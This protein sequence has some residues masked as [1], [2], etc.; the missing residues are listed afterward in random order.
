MWGP[1]PRHGVGEYNG[2]IPDLLRLGEQSLEISLTPRHW[3]FPRSLPTMAPVVVLLNTFRIGGTVT[4]G[5][6][7]AEKAEYGRQF[8]DLADPIGRLDDFLCAPGYILEL[9]MS[10]NIHPLRASQAMFLE[11]MPGEI[12]AGVAAAVGRTKNYPP[13]R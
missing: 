1:R 7:M 11:Q 6:E 9:H 4:A 3:T 13:V 10:F 5:V 12:L 8:T 2:K